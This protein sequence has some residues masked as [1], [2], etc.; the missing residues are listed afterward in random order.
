[1]YY[2]AVRRQGAINEMYCEL[3]KTITKEELAV[4]KKKDVGRKNPV[5]QNFP[6]SFC[7]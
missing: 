7:K 4:L 1:M 5:W 2:K 6:E 3:Y